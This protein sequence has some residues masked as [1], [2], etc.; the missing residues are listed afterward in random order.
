MAGLFHDLAQPVKAFRHRKGRGRAAI[1]AL[2]QSGRVVI[3]ILAC[4]VAGPRCVA[5]P[6][7]Q[8]G[9]DLF[10]YPHFD[11]W[12][13]AGPAC[14]PIPIIEVHQEFRGVGLISDC[15]AHRFPASAQRGVRDGS[16]GADDDIRTTTGNQVL[17]GF[18]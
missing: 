10:A 18:P 12:V 5:L 11:A 17:D 13:L 14:K 8:P 3:Q 16:F 6:P 9:I 1:R 2:Y 15:I 7:L 4:A